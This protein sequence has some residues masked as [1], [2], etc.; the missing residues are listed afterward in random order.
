ME[1]VLADLHDVGQDHIESNQGGH[2]RIRGNPFQLLRG[3]HGIEVDSDGPQGQHGMIGND[4][5]RAG[6][7]VQ[8]HSISFLHTEPPQGV[9]QPQHLPAQVVEGHFR[10]VEL[11]GRLIRKAVGRIVQKILGRDSGI[12]Q[13]DR[14]FIIVVALPGSGFHLH[15]LPLKAMNET[16]KGR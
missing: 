10:A 6:G 16:E 9:G 3:V 14:D 8:A 2:P 15:L 7:Q 5:L 4:V 1:T 11:I 13:G 12:T